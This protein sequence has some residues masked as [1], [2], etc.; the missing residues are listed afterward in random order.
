M[1]KKERKK[2]IKSSAAKRGK[3]YSDI[4]LDYIIEM[5]LISYE[6]DEALYN[7]VPKDYSVFIK[8]IKKVQDES[9]DDHIK[10]YAEY[11]FG[12]ILPLHIEELKD[13]TYTY[14]NFEQII[15][16]SDNWVGLIDKNPE[17]P[18]KDV[19]F[20]INSETDLIIAEY[21]KNSKYPWAIATGIAHCYYIKNYV[22]DNPNK[23]LI[24]RFYENN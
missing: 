7:N 21:I 1:T 22:R 3:I 10:S 16:S 2:E 18:T 12:A 19:Q 23:K 15:E 4:E 5:E 11:I 13:I 20:L 9:V 14:D 6:L 17:L 24:K 8:F